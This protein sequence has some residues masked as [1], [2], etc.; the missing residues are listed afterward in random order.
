MKFEPNVYIVDDDAEMRSALHRLVR[1]AGMGAKSFASAMEF[2]DAYHSDQPG[3]LLLDVQMPCMSGLELQ[4]RLKL[5]H[6]H[7]PII[8]LTGYGNVSAAVS[9]MKLGA[10]DF[11]EKPF[12]NE[13]LLEHLHKAIKMDATARLDRRNRNQISQRLAR[14]TPREHEVMD[15]LVTGKSN[16]AIADLLE[17]SVRTVET[18]RANIMSKLQAE[19]LSNLV[20]MMLDFRDN[21]AG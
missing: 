16:K 13:V 19:S 10:L 5:E 14:L 8:F 20:K 7:I 1:S 12:D 11:L 21:K 4:Q 2:L 6:I 18:H 15:M 17:V 3:C 9:A